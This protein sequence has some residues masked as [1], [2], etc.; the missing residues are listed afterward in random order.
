MPPGGTVSRPERLV[1]IV[2]PISQWRA[3]VKQ[4]DNINNANP[5][6][7]DGARSTYSLAEVIIRRA[8]ELNDR[9]PGDLA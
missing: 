4:L 7:M 3:L 5:V 6:A 8:V 1:T 2:L 9:K